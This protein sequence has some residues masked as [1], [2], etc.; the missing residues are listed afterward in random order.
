MTYLQTVSGDGGGGAGGV[1]VPDAIR[2]VGTSCP[3]W[4]ISFDLCGNVH[5]MRIR[6]TASVDGMSTAG[7][8]LMLRTARGG[9]SGLVLNALL[10]VG[11]V[12]ADVCFSTWIALCSGC[13]G[14]LSYGDHAAAMEN[15]CEVVCLMERCLDDD[16]GA[17][18]VVKATPCL[19]WAPSPSM[20][21]TCYPPV[22]AKPRDCADAPGA[23]SCSSSA[24]V[25][26]ATKCGCR[27]RACLACGRLCGPPCGG[28]QRVAAVTAGGSRGCA[29]AVVPSQCFSGPAPLVSTGLYP[30]ADA[31]QPCRQEWHQKREVDG[32]RGRRV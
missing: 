24:S 2:L 26:S 25:L 7:T 4:P 12:R 20:T 14:V 28:V 22:P 13:G 3:V 21:C 29:R 15:A 27:Y 31:C 1:S 10:R 9:Q 23:C 6:L 8:V 17:G 19:R 16:G 5:D 11:G 32:I 30:G 18:V